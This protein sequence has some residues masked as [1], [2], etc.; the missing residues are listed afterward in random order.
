M[1]LVTVF[2]P[3]GVAF[4]H[5]TLGTMVNKGSFFQ[6]LKDRWGSGSGVRVEKPAGGR[7]AGKAAATASRAEPEPIQPRSGNGNGNGSG[8]VSSTFQPAETRSSRKM[9]DREEAML[10]VGHHF[11]ELSSLMRGSQA[12]NDEKLQKIVDATSSIPVLGEQ[13]L[14]TLKSLSVQMEKQNELGV[15]LSSTMTRLPD[16]LESVERAL[17]RAAKT[18]ERTA[19]TVMEFQN[20]MDRIHTSM[21]K[22]VEHSGDQAK[23]S[24]ELAERGTEELKSLATGIAKTQSGAVEELK[25]AT[26][27]GL[28]Q[29]R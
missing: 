3:L 9:S 10:T 11:Q 13:Q 5:A 4:G 15:Q 23:A 1:L 14:D 24:Q 6:R 27:Q 8:A 22:M 17:E 12:A 29:L 28:Q 2:G 19:A 20:T 26:D 7:A 18:D 25:R 16:L 21:D